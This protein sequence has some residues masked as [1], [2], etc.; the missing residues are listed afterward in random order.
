MTHRPS[1]AL[2]IETSNGY[3]RGLLEGITAYVRAHDAWSIWLPE[4]RRGETPP[5]WLGRWKGD[6]VIA[7][8]ETPEIAAA[9]RKLKVPV[10]DVSAART[11]PEIPWV[12]TDDAAI[13]RLGAEHLAERGFRRLGFVG[14]PRF[15]WSTWRQMHFERWCVD[16]D[17]ECHTFAPAATKDDSP[18]K[19][20]DRLRRWLRGLPQPI[21]ILT[22]YDIKGQLVLDAC[23]ELGIAVPEQV[24]VLSVDNDE[25]L[26]NLCTPPLSSIEPDSR[27]TGALAA[28]LLNRMLSGEDVPPQ[29]YLL[30]PLGV[31]ARRSTDVL[32]IEDREV[33]T[34]LRYIREH[35]REGIDVS[36]VLRAT[37]LSRR[38]LEARFRDAVGRSPHQEIL[39]VRLEHVCRLLTQTD[40]SLAEIAART[41]FAHPEYLTVAFKRE[42]GQPPSLFRREHASSRPAGN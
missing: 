28:E 34:A 4:Q 5:V 41:G 25:L 37:P 3:A 13:A 42:L 16:A 40:L 35:A 31:I 9:V 27:R 36:H 10:I 20:A 29:A 14:D 21:G 8:I 30:P 11:L 18:A 38:V 23:R 33:A 19:E 7:R 22:C 26:C 15:N 39:R 24:A 1:V 6:G 12:E 32:A 2:L 17:I